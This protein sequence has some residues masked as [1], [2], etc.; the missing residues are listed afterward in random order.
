MSPTP[1]F[2]YVAETAEILADSA[3]VADVRDPAAGKLLA[4]APELRDALKALAEAV[5]CANEW[6][7][8][9]AESGADEDDAADAY[10]AERA[11]LSGARAALAKVGL[12]T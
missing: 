12:W 3:A 9:E 7:A 1:R 6:R 10:D 5:E 11:A 2:E 4:A 8:T